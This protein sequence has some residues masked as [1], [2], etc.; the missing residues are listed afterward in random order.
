MKNLLNRLSLTS[1]TNT[2]LILTIISC[3]IAII[4]ILPLIELVEEALLGLKNSTFGL[5]LDGGKQVYG[6]VCLLLGT[7]L[8]GGTIGTVNGWLL[9]NCRF[10]GRKVL[11]ITQ[12]L[13]L[14]TPS[15]LLS[16]ILIDLGSIYSVRVHGMAW[17]ILIMSLTT[18]PYVFLLSNENFSISGKQQLEACRSLGIGAWQSFWRIALPMALPAIGTGIALM[19]MEVVNELGAVQ[20]LNI[21]SISAGIIENWI[22]NGN[23][24]GAIT[25]AFIAL[26]IVMALIGY[27]KTLRGK[28]KRWSEGIE[29]GE[30]ASWELKGVRAILAQLIAAIPPL[31]TLGVPIIWSLINIEQINQG[32]NFEL[33]ILS[34]RSL[35]LALTAAFI[36]I[37]AAIILSLAKRWSKSSFIKYLTFLAGI[38]YAIPGA[39]LAIGLFTFS[40]PPFK[41]IP[42]ILL[43]WGYGDRFLAVAKGGLDAAFERTS[44]SLDEAATNLGSGWRKV[45]FKIH[46]P[47]L[48][49]PIGVGIIL[50]FVDTLKE[51]PLTFVLRPFDFD[52]LSV[53]IY[54]YA[55]DERMAES[56]LPAMII[57][58]FGL[59]ASASLIKN[60]DQRNTENKSI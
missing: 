27:E 41:L 8:I 12:L 57:L 3:S 18:Y 39:V 45:L 37:I 47:L 30:A 28:S 6:T 29:G 60:L 2:R 16:A 22:S 34:L 20:F 58:I 56:I 40:G 49:G 59:I 5:G 10:P 38:G 24:S 51:L 42:I 36:T 31:I 52:T 1:L 15:Y 53:R 17:G 9:A 23:P 4:V 13:P 55:S 11:R 33:L 43:L 50:V 14:A 7:G 19:G 54:Q 48:K 35:G 44:P 21:P 26:I 32:F 46:L 25:L